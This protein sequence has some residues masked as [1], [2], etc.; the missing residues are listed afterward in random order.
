MNNTDTIFALSSASGKAGVAVIR[1]SGDNLESIAAK[2]INKENIEKRRAYFTNL[3]DENFE[4]IDQCLILYF[5]APNSFTGQD[6]IE[7]QSHG[8]PAVI[9]KIFNYLQKQ[10]MR[11]AAPGVFSRRALYNNKM[12]LSEADGLS[13]LLS[14]RTERQRKLA[15]QSM[16]GRDSKIYENWRAQMIEISAFAAAILDYASDD[17]PKDIDKT[18]VTKTQNLHDE[19]I[20]SINASTA[21]RAVQSGFNIVLTGK[22]NVGKSSIFNRIVGSNRAIVSDVHGTTR[23]VVSYQL[24]IDGY[25][26]N[27]SDTA[28]LRESNDL[29]ENIGI[30]KTDMEVKNADLVINVQSADCK[31]QFKDLKDNEILVINKSDL[32][33]NLAVTDTP[34]NTVFV[35]AK[36]GDGFEDLMKKVR[37]KMHNIMDGTESDLAVNARTKALLTETVTELKYALDSGENY[38]IF[39]E[40]TR[41]AADNIGKILGTISVTEIADRVFS[42]LCLGK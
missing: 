12:D 39:A 3:R 37:E 18:I 21:V 38:D 31:A 11:M 22:T 7:I 8:A 16:I 10:N 17:L 33:N 32:I 5:Q 30:E 13:A 25:L 9:E 36:T 41:T 35:S 42:G 24:D 40:H 29:V 28:G 15:L 26:V 14:A 34:T 27:L 6:L 20:N 1:I 23:D 2:F 4:L 19:I